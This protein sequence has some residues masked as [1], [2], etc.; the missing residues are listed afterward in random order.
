ME[1]AITSAGWHQS[2]NDSVIDSVNRKWSSPNLQSTL[3]TLTPKR[4][5]FL[6]FSSLGKKWKSRVTCHSDNTSSSALVLFN[7][8]TL[9]LICR[10]G[11]FVSLISKTN[12]FYCAKA[13]RTRVIFSLTRPFPATATKN[14]IRI[15]NLKNRN[16]RNW[17]YTMLATNDGKI[18][19]MATRSYLRN[20][21]AQIRVAV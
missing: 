16:P 4:K 17:I 2:R 6:L 10:S 13:N 8:V 21:V 12:Y 14:N 1:T 15:L 9:P 3:R 20:L 19:I 18:T 5:W 7:I 11:A